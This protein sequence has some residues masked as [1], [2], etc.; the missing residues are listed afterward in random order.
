MLLGLLSS[1]Q[2]R[3][4]LQ[5]LLDTPGATDDLEL[6]WS[7]AAAATDP[8]MAHT[9]RPDSDTDQQGNAALAAVR[10]AVN[11]A[12]AMASAARQL[13]AATAVAEAAGAVITVNT[14]AARAAGNAANDSITE[15]LNQD[16]PGDLS[17]LAASLTAAAEAAATAA[18]ISEVELVPGGASLAVSEGNKQQYV[19]AMV[20][21]K[22]L[23]YCREQVGSG[24]DARCVSS[25]RCFIAAAVSCSSHT[26]PTTINRQGCLLNV[27]KHQLHVLVSCR[28]ITAAVLIIQAPTCYCEVATVSAHLPRLSL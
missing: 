28:P 4:S 9:H 27:T 2:V 12:R 5:Y 10:Q 23:G 20:E 22:L 18:G 3:S 24:C 25:L 14:A 8:V 26:L 1:L 17:R 15:Q 19:Q 21:H 11:A 13:A 16:I 6:T 7:A